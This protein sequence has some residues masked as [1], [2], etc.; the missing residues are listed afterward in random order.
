VQNSF[1]CTAAGSCAIAIEPCCKGG[2][3]CTGAYKPT[4]N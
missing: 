1:D 2:A 3:T 4:C